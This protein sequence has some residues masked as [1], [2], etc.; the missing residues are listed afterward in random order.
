MK[1]T[2][3][4]TLEQLS[5]EHGETGWKHLR[6]EESSIF[7]ARKQLELRKITFKKSILTGENSEEMGLK[8]SKT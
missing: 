3:Y 1:K 6:S 4:H 8:C 2:T 7:I 5:F